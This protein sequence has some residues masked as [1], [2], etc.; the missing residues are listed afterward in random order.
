MIHLRA[1]A[2]YFL[3]H[4]HIYTT[5]SVYKSSH[6]RIYVGPSKSE[7]RG[8]AQETYPNPKENE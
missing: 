1:A 2:S 3:I 7:V 4:S 6:M 5:F 8:T